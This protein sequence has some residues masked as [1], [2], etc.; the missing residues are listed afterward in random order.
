MP[1]PESFPGRPGDGVQT[2]P[3]VLSGIHADW[4]HVA[5]RSGSYSP[6]ARAVDNPGPALARSDSPNQSLRNLALAR[7]GSPA[8]S[9]GPGGLTLLNR[10][11]SQPSGIG[12]GD[13]D[14]KAL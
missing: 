7:S 9:A 6:T 5:L 11:A 4:Q 1:E 10:S 13:G 3:T 14:L 2:R 12:I 8:V